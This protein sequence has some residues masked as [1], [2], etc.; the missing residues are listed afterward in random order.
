MKIEEDEM[1]SHMQEAL[2]DDLWERY[3]D[4]PELEGEEETTSKSKEILIKLWNKD[5][6][7]FKGGCKKLGHNDKEINKTVKTILKEGFD[8]LKD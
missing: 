7:L 8:Y 1:V 2:S 4:E 6:E 3:G 5:I